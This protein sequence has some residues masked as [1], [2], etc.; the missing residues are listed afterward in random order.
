MERLTF[1]LSLALAIISAMSIVTLMLAITV[2][3]IFRFVSRS[4]VP[5][6]IE[7]AESSLIV[8]VF[9]GLAWAGLKGEHVAVTLLSDRLGP[10]TNRVL[11]L[12]VWTLVSL[13]LTWMLYATTIRAISSTQASEERFGLVRWP[14]YPLRWVIVIGLAAFLVVAVTNLVRVLE[15]KRPLGSGNESDS[16][17]WS[18]PK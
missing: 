14:L 15:G 7:L 18:N 1:R 11:D 3:V 6:L 9:F 17:T 10:S 16:E 13:F 2:D 5:G 8:A 4:S 12:V